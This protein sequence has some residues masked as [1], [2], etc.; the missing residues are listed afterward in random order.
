[1]ALN[2]DPQ[3]NSWWL[4]SDGNWYPPELHRGVGSSPPVDD[5]DR[6]AALF[7]AAIGVARVRESVVALASSERRSGYSTGGNGND[8]HLGPQRVNAG[9]RA[10]DK[11]VGVSHGTEAPPR[12]RSGQT[13]DWTY[14]ARDPATLDAPR[15]ETRPRPGTRERPVHQPPPWSP[16][17][18]D[19][20]VP[21]R[22]AAEPRRPPLAEPEQGSGGP[23]FKGAPAAPP[24]STAPAESTVPPV[25]PLEPPLPEPPVPPPAPPVPPLEPPLPEPPVPPPAPPV[26]EPPPP[27]EPELVATVVPQPPPPPL[28]PEL[29]ATVVPQ[30]PPS[31]LEPELSAPT[32][33]E[34]E[35]VPAPVQPA[36]AL[37]PT[38]AAGPIPAPAPNN[39]PPTARRRPATGRPAADLRQAVAGAVARAAAQGPLLPQGPEEASLTP[40]ALQPPPAWPKSRRRPAPFPPAH[41]STLPV[42]ATPAVPAEEL[43]APQ[44]SIF[45]E[46]EPQ[47][48]DPYEEFARLAGRHAAALAPR[49]HTDRPQTLPPGSAEAD[50]RPEHE[51][52][53]PVVD[54]PPAGLPSAFEPSPLWLASRAGASPMDIATPDRPIA[55]LVDIEVDTS[56]AADPYDDFADLARRYASARADAPSAPATDSGSAGPTSPDET[57]G[58]SALSDAPQP[59]PA[60]AE[61]APA[62]E[63]APEPRDSEPSYPEPDG[64]QASRAEEETAWPVGERRSAARQARKPLPAALQAAVAGT[65]PADATTASPRPAARQTRGANEDS[66]ADTVRASGKPPGIF[67]RYAS[68]IAVVALFVAAGGAAAGIAAL[69]GPIAQTASP[70]PA[71]EQ[72]AASQAVLKASDFPAGWHVSSGSSSASYGVGSVLV[73]PSIVRFWL[74]AHPA[75]AATLDAVSGAMMPAS[76]NPSA[77][78]SSH[79]TSQTPLGESWQIASAVAFHFSSPAQVT[80]QVTGIRNLL[81]GAAA[82]ACIGQFW[83]AALLAESPVGSHVVTTVSPAAVP[84]LPGNPASWAMSMSGSTT[85]GRVVLPIHFEIVVLASGLA[86]V[87]F[88]TASKIAPLPAG[89]DQGLLTTLATRAQHLPS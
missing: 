50:A 16:S 72:A 13:T 34:P 26:P 70:T 54:T 56:A 43:P 46:T 30:P 88:V 2:D 10:S 18:Y 60:P 9:R 45:V 79:A 27:L 44:S 86:Q 78:A 52:E 29:V 35:P 58:G 23:P 24:E 22:P 28:E 55:A 84:A 6:F 51:P 32:F 20:A 87:Y 81:A 21:A 12:F 17:G 49:R 39:L 62:T 71:Q 14:E 69:R 73:T 65:P 59:D 5:E 63:T 42:T 37:E 68:A 82:R 8:A 1:M 40:E 11:V 64:P 33:D 36:P 19:R 48:L 38:P 3:A 66:Q 74:N 75:C 89:L 31:P 61:V 57:P 83:S 47:T 77:S 67:R 76:G 7:D 25:P 80:G 41:S 15:P 53:P 85:V 4:A